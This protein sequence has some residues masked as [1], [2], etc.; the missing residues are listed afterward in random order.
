MTN[1]TP[2]FKKTTEAT[3]SQDMTRSLESSPQSPQ[4][5]E[6]EISVLFQE[7]AV[8][9]DGIETHAKRQ[10][11]NI[12][13]DL[14]RDLEGKIPTDTIASEIVHQLHGKVSERLVHDCLEEKYKRKYR[15]DN[16]RKQKHRKQISNTDLAAPVPLKRE[17]IVDAAG[18]E[19]AP[20]VAHRTN[21]E[22]T[23]YKVSRIDEGQ[24]Q[25]SCSNCD[26]LEQK[27]EQQHLKLVE[28]ED[29]IR[30]QTSIQTAEEIK[31]SITDDYFE[32][33]F[34]IP[35]E[36]LRLR[37]ISSFNLNSSVDRVWF[38]G[39]LNPEKTKIGNVEVLKITAPGGLDD[40]LSDT[41]CHQ[42]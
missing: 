36:T 7:A 6:Q 33:Q 19:T 3:H 2:D 30:T 40:T 4:S 14:A 5:A 13:Q 1:S 10:K 32:F 25:E 18:I 16:A 42:P 11:I 34:S 28:C 37:M 9:L 41:T 21:H 17:I 15:V 12:I 26:L 38:T 29:I 39:K 24:G 27:Y 22:N 20:I 8:K 31:H 23:E 35:F